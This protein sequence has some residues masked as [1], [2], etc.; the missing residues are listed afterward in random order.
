MEVGGEVSAVGEG[1]A[2]EDNAGP[3]PAALNLHMPYVD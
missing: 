1:L 3:R 2:T